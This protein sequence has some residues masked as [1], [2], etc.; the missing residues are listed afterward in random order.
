MVFWTLYMHRGKA[1][2]FYKLTRALT[3]ACSR[4]SST[5][6]D[7]RCNNALVGKL[8]PVDETQ[9]ASGVKD[10]LQIGKN[11]LHQLVFFFNDMISWL[12]NTANQMGTPDPI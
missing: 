12:D 4:H 8:D 1:I 9:K 3:L 2:R 11:R 7:W 6:G 5:S 10:C